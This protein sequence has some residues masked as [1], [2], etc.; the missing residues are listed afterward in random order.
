M[1]FL[2]GFDEDVFISYADF[3]D[4]RIG[5]ETRGWVEQLHKDLAATIPTFLTESPQLWRDCSIDNNEDFAK[6]IVNRLFHTA[7]LLAVLS[8]SY[9]ERPWCKKE[10]EEFYT[11]AGKELQLGDKR[12]IFTV[13][14]RPLT[15][16]LPPQF[17]G[18]GVY[19]FYTCDPS[20]PGCA[21]QLRVS[22]GKEDF[23]AY[24]TQLESLARNIA[25]TLKLMRSQGAGA[26]AAGA[27][28]RAVYL[29]E[30]TDDQSETR[31]QIRRDL[32]TRG[33]P[34][35]PMGSLPTSGGKF[36]QEV[37]E[38]LSKSDLS[39][40]IFGLRAGFKPEDQDR[41]C[42]WLQHDLA[43]ERGKDAEF[44]RIVWLP[45][46][47]EAA[48]EDQRKYLE[49][50]K[51]EATPEHGAEIL[52]GKIEELKSEVNKKL[53][54]IE[55]RRRERSRPKPA[56][57][58]SNEAAGEGADSGEPPMVYLICDKRDLP[59][60]TFRQLEKALIKSGCETVKSVSTESDE[61]GR[62]VHEKCLQEC[63]AY[64]VYY[65]AADEARVKT[66][67]KDCRKLASKRIAPI[68]STAVYVA[69]PFDEL[70]PDF[71]TSLATHVILGGAEFSDEQLAPFVAALQ[72]Q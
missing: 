3:D 29:A 58:A 41:G 40:H 72:R 25:D 19:R 44:R 59:S 49:G 10:L 16:D 32:Q 39:I 24:I 27:E 61:E 43:V 12:R 68:R 18:T 64:L 45:A 46:D 70:K 42:T 6:K 2:R 66:N 26:A 67:L 20:Q 57:E 31:E 48:K 23:R 38:C 69:P 5:E 37:R 34:V 53:K 9:L 33:I 55:D 56:E 50:L 60:A 52:W 8:D 7:I 54:E 71:Q 30:T 1:G 28:A 11:K 35:L 51:S 17:E 15:R 63:D 62:K 65:G 13:G 21:H 36:E 4:N 14:V 47:L 22:L